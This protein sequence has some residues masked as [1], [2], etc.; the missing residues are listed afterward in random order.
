LNGEP[1]EATRLNDGDEILL[2]SKKLRIFSLAAGKGAVTTAP[3]AESPA[4]PPEPEELVLPEPEPTPVREEVPKPR[5]AART[6]SAGTPTIPGYKVDRLL[7]RGAMGNVYLST[8]E[9]LDRR[10]ALKVLKT[11]L[12]GRAAQSPEHRDRLRRRPIRRAAL[13]FHGVHG[14]GLHRGQARGA[15][16]APVA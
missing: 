10:V 16:A 9:S 5:P 3:P 11:K 7:G 14:G 12:A 6:A 1:V 8:Q 15:R 2:G 4:E 13:P